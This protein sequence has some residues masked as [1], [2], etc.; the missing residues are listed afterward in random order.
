MRSSTNVWDHVIGMI[1]YGSKTPLFEIGKYL[2]ME[3][4][5][6][7]SALVR[8]K[9]KDCTKIYENLLT[10]ITSTF[11]CPRLC[12]R[13]GGIGSALLPAGAATAAASSLP[14]LNAMPRI[15]RNNS[16]V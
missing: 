5:T 8:P 11:P 7:R 9:S 2:T 1:T 10:I 13:E 14:T 6:V 16:Q 12:R 3:F 4:T 15:I